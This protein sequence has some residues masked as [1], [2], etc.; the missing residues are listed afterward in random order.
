[1]SDDAKERAIVNKANELASRFCRAMGYVV[2]VNYRFDKAR[3]P[4]ERLCWQMACDAFEFVEGT[5]PR[6]AL[7]SIKE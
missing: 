4:Q 2:P 6:D 1:M 3:H 5:D 7:A